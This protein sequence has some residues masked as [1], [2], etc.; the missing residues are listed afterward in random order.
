MRENAP[1]PALPLRVEPVLQCRDRR[2]TWRRDYPIVDGSY[3]EQTADDSVGDY[4]LGVTVSRWA[5]DGATD[6]KPLSPADPLS[7]CGHELRIV[8]TLTDDAGT[9]WT[10]ATPWML[11]TSW[12]ESEDGSMLELAAVGRLEGLWTHALA[13][14]KQFQAGTPARE[15]IASLLAGDSVEVTWAS[16]IS[17]QSIPRGW[18]CGTD[19]LASVSELLEALGANLRERE[20]GAVIVRAPGVVKDRPVLLLNDG[21]GGTVVSIPDSFERAS[22][23]NHVVVR[24][25]A[26]KGKDKVSFVAEAREI[27]GPYDP[28]TYGWV[29]ETL[30]NNA[31]TDYAQA[32]ALAEQRLYEN[33]ILGRVLDCTA[34][35][36]WRIEL[37][38]AIEVVWRGRTFWGRV[39]GLELPLGQSAEMRIKIGVQ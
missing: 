11:Q 2:R 28:A 22:R 9:E 18:A 13:A 24:G 31:C 27:G 25:E 15:A 39:V 7:A 14:A 23:S 12:A 36:D 32:K 35:T 6:R 26:D 17:S 5:P 21:D 3:A 33:R 8:W 37:D 20:T 1:S 29:S 10:I 30:E 38:D 34:A 4:K 19:R 16:N